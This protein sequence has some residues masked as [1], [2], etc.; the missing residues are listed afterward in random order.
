MM[1]L[2]DKTTSW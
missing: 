1:K 2:F